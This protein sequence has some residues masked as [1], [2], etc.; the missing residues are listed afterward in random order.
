[1]AALGQRYEADDVS[2]KLSNCAIFSEP[3]L[4]AIDEAAQ[5]L[6]SLG[7]S[8]GPAKRLM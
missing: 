8:A 4:D 6:R 1:M 3:D 2:D 5:D 7:A